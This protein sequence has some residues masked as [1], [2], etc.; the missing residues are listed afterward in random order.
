MTE[1]R[2]EVSTRFDGQEIEELQQYT[3]EKLEIQTILRGV[4]IK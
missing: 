1:K 4:E 3:E 2:F